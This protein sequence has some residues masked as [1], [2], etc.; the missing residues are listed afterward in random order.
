MWQKGL[1]FLQKESCG[2]GWLWQ[3]QKLCLLHFGVA[4][5]LQQIARWTSNSEVVGSSPISGA[6]NGVGLKKTLQG[7]RRLQGSL[8]F[9]GD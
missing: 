8:V 7:T 9:D 1:A 6:Y 4:S 2:H 3:L 5:V